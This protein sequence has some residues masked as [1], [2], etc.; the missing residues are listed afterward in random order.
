MNADHLAGIVR[1]VVEARREAAGGQSSPVFATT[2]GP[3]QL[4]SRGTRYSQ[5]LQMN[6]RRQPNS[7]PGMPANEKSRLDDEPGLP[8]WRKVL[9]CGYFRG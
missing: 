5:P 4:Y 8:W 9:S 2:R 1:K 7:T 6:L 3:S